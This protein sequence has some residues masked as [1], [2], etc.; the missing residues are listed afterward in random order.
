MLLDQTSLDYLSMEA[1]GFRRYP[2]IIMD[3]LSDVSEKPSSMDSSVTCYDSARARISFR[4][5][6]GKLQ[7]QPCRYLGDK[8]PGRSVVAEHILVRHSRPRARRL[9]R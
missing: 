9:L 4:E 2:I 5:W 1:I 3:S 8:L 6:V 7:A